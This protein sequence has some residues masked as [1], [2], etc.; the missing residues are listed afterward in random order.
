MATPTIS[1]FK[2]FIHALRG[3]LIKWPLLASLVFLL[4]V[5]V[6]RHFAV[7]G[8]LC[9]LLI[10]GLGVIYN[11]LLFT[12]EVE[13]EE[14][15]EGTLLRGPE[16]R[17]QL[18]MESGAEAIT[19]LYDRF[20]L[21]RREVLG[22]L[23]LP[24]IS[25]NARE[26]FSPMVEENSESAVELFNHLL[27]LQQHLNALTSM[28]AGSR[29]TFALKAKQITHQREDIITHIDDLVRVLE[30]VSVDVPQFGTEPVDEARERL[31]RLEGSL[32]TSKRAWEQLRNETEDV[33]KDEQGREL[34]RRSKA[35]RE[36][37]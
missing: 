6:L 16:L 11:L 34:G 35:R 14:D 5:P 37:Q 33:L 36:R 28:E 1:K 9:G 25:R 8:I 29:G 12:D 26:Q 3:P 23:A 27:F 32:N 15:Q 2:L 22:T 24:N 10:A 13:Q 17:T 4:L 18:S 7:A 31:G 30:Q 19:R 20:E 21:I